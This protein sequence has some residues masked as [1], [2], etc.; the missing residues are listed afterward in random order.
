MTQ[1]TT[2]LGFTG[3][4]QGEEKRQHTGPA[5]GSESVGQLATGNARLNADDAAGGV[6]FEDVDEGG[7]VDLEVSLL[8][9]GV[10]EG[11]G[12]PGR[13]SCVREDGEWR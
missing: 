3:G 13:A 4:G 12:L 6:D 2:C 10:E 9:L 8:V 5:E 1:T 7:Q 11:S